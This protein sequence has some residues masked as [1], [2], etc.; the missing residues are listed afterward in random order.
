[1]L[2]YWWW[3]QISCWRQFWPTSSAVRNI[4]SHLSQLQIERK[5]RTHFDTTRSLQSSQNTADRLALCSLDGL[6]KPSSLFFHRRP[7]WQWSILWFNQT[8]K[9]ISALELPLFRASSMF[10][11]TLFF[12]QSRLLKSFYQQ[13]VLHHLR[14]NWWSNDTFFRWKHIPWFTWSVDIVDCS[15]VLL[16]GHTL[17]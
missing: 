2:G 4:Y 1:M 9:C 5:V 16:G 14:T 6:T 12:P 15:L 10:L 11:S 17:C 8:S 3:E 13:H 7:S